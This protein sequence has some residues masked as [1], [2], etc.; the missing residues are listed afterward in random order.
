MPAKTVYIYRAMGIYDKV[1]KR[2]WCHNKGEGKFGKEER[3]INY[4]GITGKI[5]HY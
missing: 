2:D 5:L 3:K 1:Y 4:M